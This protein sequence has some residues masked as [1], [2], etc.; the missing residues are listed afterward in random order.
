MSAQPCHVAPPSNMIKLSCR[1]FD[2]EEP[3]PVNIRKAIFAGSVDP[4]V[5]QKQRR[6]ETS[7]HSSLNC[8][9]E[10][11]DILMLQASTVTGQK[12]DSS[13]TVK[14]SRVFQVTILTRPKEEFSEEF[15][16]AQFRFLRIHL[17]S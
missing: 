14:H 1:V 7:T 13:H 8:R 2:N 3:C 16:R 4:K 10:E 6:T 9:L 5:F 11:V 12:V 15:L 17:D